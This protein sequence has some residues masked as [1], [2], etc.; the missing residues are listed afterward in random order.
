MI[1]QLESRTFF[2]VSTVLADTSE[3][4]IEATSVKE[5]FKYFKSNFLNA[6]LAVIRADLVNSFHAQELSAEDFRVSIHLGLGLEGGERTKLAA[7]AA[8][9]NALLKTVATHIAQVVG[10][11]NRLAAKPTNAS[12]QKL[13]KADINHLEIA[14]LGKQAKFHADLLGIVDAGNTA[15]DKIAALT[16]NDDQTQFDI[17][18]TQSDIVTG[19]GSLR[20]DIDL[21][22]A[23]VAQVET[24]AAALT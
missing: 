20:A 9:G 2:S 19:T 1:E 21:Y 6:D 16:T 5:Q 24:D 8:G 17:T 23:A 4:N 14:T 15:L 3:V 11:V 7:L 18:N 22:F 13:L 12:L 10:D